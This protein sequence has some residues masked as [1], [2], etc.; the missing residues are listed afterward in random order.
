MVPSTQAELTRELLTAMHEVVSWSQVQLR[1]TLDRLELTAP[2]SEALWALD[3]EL[4]A[5]SMKVL[6]G[7]LHCDPSSATFLV[8]RL[9][10]QGFIE[11]VPD[12]ADRRSKTVELTDKGAKVRHELIEA[13]ID[14]SPL[15]AL[16]VPD[17]EDALRLLRKAL[18]RASA[19][20]ENLPDDDR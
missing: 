17:Q 14:Q 2:L 11:R 3:P 18:S 8:T 5:P 13:M 1:T 7:R 10:R 6:A 12:P 16:G 19:A 15:T 9:E 4:P 20:W